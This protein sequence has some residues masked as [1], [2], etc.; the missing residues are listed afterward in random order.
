MTLRTSELSSNTILRYTV[1]VSMVRVLQLMIG[2]A[3]YHCSCVRYVA[4]LNIELTSGLSVGL[5]ILLI[6]LITITVLTVQR[7]IRRR[8]LSGEE[9]M[10]TPTE[11]NNNESI[12]YSESNESTHYN[13]R[14]PYDYD[15]YV[16]RS[17]RFNR[18]TLLAP[19]LQAAAPFGSSAALDL[20]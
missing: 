19:H 16:R 10:D 1:Y 18:T 15:D 3:K 9:Q 11:Q 17:V 2:N 12:E 5:G 6:L 4:Q 20:L 13:R 8:K 7:K 14:L